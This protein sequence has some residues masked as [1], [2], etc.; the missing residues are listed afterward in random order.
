[1]DM[2]VPLALALVLSVAACGTSRYAP[3]P[4]VPMPSAVDA[5]PPHHVAG[6]EMSWDVFW[7]GIAIGRAAMVVT[8][9]DVRCSFRT[10]TLAS[11][12]AA[13]RYQL[14]TTLQRGEVRAL[15]EALAIDGDHAQHAAR[16]DGTTYML[17][18]GAPRR[19]P[20]GT[21]LHTVGSTINVL[22]TW[23][24]GDA[25]RGYLWLLHD[26]ALFRVDVR[27]PVRDEALGRAALRIEGEVRSPERQRQLAVTIWLAANR[28][29]TPLRFAVETDEHRI[30]AELIETNTSIE[31]R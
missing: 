27:P 3:V 9:A 18:D 19:V 31:P 30:T 29:R 24:R 11:A 15:A 17:R 2:V 25:Q 21:R 12:L 4:D 23:S 22:R 14:T 13:V 26:G 5:I 16:I 1:M 8:P 28:D 6:E 7:Q 10:G 20:G